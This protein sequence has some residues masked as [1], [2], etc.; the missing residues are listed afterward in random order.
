M[1]PYREQGTIFLTYI[2]K[3]MLASSHMDWTISAEKLVYTIVQ[4]GSLGS[5]LQNRNED[6]F[7]WFCAITKAAPGLVE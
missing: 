3:K 4:C 6:A 1:P 7:C 2:I 5:K